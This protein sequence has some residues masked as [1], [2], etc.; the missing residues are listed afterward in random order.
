MIFSPD[1]ERND[2]EKRICKALEQVASEV[3]AKS[4]TSGVYL[5]QPHVSQKKADHKSSCYRVCHA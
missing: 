1:W 4:I 2:K 5:P 3:G